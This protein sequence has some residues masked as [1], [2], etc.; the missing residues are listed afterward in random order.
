MVKWLVR[1]ERWMTIGIAA[2]VA[3]C[4]SA[5]VGFYTSA[6]SYG[7]HHRHLSPVSKIAELGGLNA[8]VLVGIVGLTGQILLTVGAST[9]EKRRDQ[10]EGARLC[11]TLLD[12]VIRLLSSRRKQICR[13]LVSVANADMT[14]RVAVCG[15]NILVD[16][17]LGAPMPIGFGI[18]GEAFRRRAMQAGNIADE[19]RGIDAS[20]SVVPGVWS[21]IRCVL[22]F[23]MMSANGKPF[24]TV[25]FDSDKTLEMSGLGDRNVQDALARVVQLV[26]YLMRSYGPDRSARFPT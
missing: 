6:S 19:E 13:A 4:F 15:A 23:P 3:I 2:V 20:G 11:E 1:N 21:D 22:A 26:T 7:G 18:A 5:Y 16:P 25:T 17:E 8:F 10:S 12:P 24:G 14:T 9:Q